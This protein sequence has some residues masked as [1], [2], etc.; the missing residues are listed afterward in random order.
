MKQRNNFDFA[1]K[2]LIIAIGCNQVD[3]AIK[4]DE[5][6]L[7]GNIKFRS[8]NEY[9]YMLM[10]FNIDYTEILTILLQ[11]LLIGNI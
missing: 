1:K 2:C 10:H 8:S 9:L 4:I 3:E 7:K 5:I 11:I 6:L